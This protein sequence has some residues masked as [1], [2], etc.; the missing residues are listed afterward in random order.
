MKP[1]GRLLL[2][3]STLAEAQFTLAGIRLMLRPSRSQLLGCFLLLTGILG[4]LVFRYLRLL[5]W[6]R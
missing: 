5:W 3:P 2:I 4:L 1:L 6:T